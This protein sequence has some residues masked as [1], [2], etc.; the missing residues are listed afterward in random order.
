MIGLRVIKKWG[1]TAAKNRGWVDSVEAGERRPKY[2]DYFC[3]KGSS[4]N[5]SESVDDSMIICNQSL[6]EKVSV[7]FY[8]NA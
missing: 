4:L 1:P 6:I 3:C 5:D 7:H 2:M 8:S